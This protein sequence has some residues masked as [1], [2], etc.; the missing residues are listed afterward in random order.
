ML[1]R[2][3]ALA[4][5]ATMVQKTSMTYIPSWKVFSIR[6]TRGTN[7]IAIPSVVMVR[8]AAAVSY[9]W[10]VSRLTPSPAARIRTE[11]PRAAARPARR[12]GSKIP[13]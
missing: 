10:G 9:S 4:M 11:R 7:E 1:A 13:A 6:L 2:A 8:M 12:L 5:E 3:A